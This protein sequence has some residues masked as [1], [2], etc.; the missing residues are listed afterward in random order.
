VLT[1]AGLIFG[2]SIVGIALILDDPNLIG[3]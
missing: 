1:G 2:T 3:L